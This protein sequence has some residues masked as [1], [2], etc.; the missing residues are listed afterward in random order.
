MICF[1]SVREQ[2]W[3]EKMVKSAHE[4]MPEEPVIQLTDMDTPEVPGVDDVIRLPWDGTGLMRYRLQ[5]LSAL[6]DQ[7]FLTCD[8]DVIFKRPLADVWAKDFDVALTYRT[9]KIELKIDFR[10]YDKG[11][12]LTETMPINTGVMFSKCSAFWS[13]AAK[14]LYDLDA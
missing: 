14:E 6:G 5:H 4:V 13:E 9:R 11:T 7:K 3:A 2:P 1:L 8:A 10:G 12:N